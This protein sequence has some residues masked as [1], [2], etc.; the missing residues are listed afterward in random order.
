[1]VSFINDPNKMKGRRVLHARVYVKSQV[2]HRNKIA[3]TNG[4][5]RS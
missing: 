1:M 3:R 5:R 2:D 4:M